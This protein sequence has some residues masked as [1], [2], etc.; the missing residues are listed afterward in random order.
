MIWY[1]F[2]FNKAWLFLLTC[3][4]PFHQKAKNFPTEISN[5]EFL[6]DDLW[7]KRTLST[8]QTFARGQET[9][10]EQ[11]SNGTTKTNGS[12]Q[13]GNGVKNGVN[14]PTNYHTLN[15]SRSNGHGIIHSSIIPLNGTLP[16]SN[17]FHKSKA[18]SVPIISFP[19]PPTNVTPGTTPPN[20][21][22]SRSLILES[23]QNQ[24]NLLSEASHSHSHSYSLSYASTDS[25]GGE[26][27][28][29]INNFVPTAEDVSLCLSYFSM[30]FSYCRV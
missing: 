20:H 13:N 10:N 15:G 29:S 5:I 27:E 19:F 14:S 9:N 24:L 21:S 26:N 22:Y 18:V 6:Q 8:F 3:S 4:N 7:T 1:T 11:D 16:K 25:A 23:E 17:G 30:L 12:L 28:F 2:L